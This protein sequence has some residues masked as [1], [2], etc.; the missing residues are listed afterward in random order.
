MSTPNKDLPMTVA[1]FDDLWN[2]ATRVSKQLDASKELHNK[3][4]DAFMRIATIQ[5]FY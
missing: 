1:H 3:T 4:N 5:A 2:S